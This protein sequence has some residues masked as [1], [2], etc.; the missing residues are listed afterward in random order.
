IGIRRWNNQFAVTTAGAY[1]LVKIQEDAFFP[2]SQPD[3][4]PASL[5]NKILYFL[6][7]TTEPA[8]LAGT[9]LLVHET[10]DQV[11]KPRGAWQY[12]PG[13]RRL[14]LATNNA[15]DNQGKA[16][17]GLGI[18]EQLDKYN[19]A[20]DRYQWKLIGKKEVYVPANSYAIH[21]DELKYSDVMKK[22]HI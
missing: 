17:D 13:H 4:D 20:M 6:Q 15:Y 19:G 9:I 7:L 2:Y 5:N 22:G 14:R 21:S 16:S 12:N 10:M 3:I 1:S 18:N 8:R 11:K